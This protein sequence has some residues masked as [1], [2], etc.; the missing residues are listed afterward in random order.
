VKFKK[1]IASLLSILTVVSMIP[2]PANAYAEEKNT[3][4]PKV[5]DTKAAEEDT[6]FIDS[7]IED[8]SSDTVDEMS[9]SEENSSAKKSIMQVS[10]DSNKI[11]VV[12]GKK[13][14]YAV[15]YSS[16]DKFEKENL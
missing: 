13:D 2:V 5:V 3:D 9:E 1:C 10:G 16:G 7:Y 14:T 15:M 8:I 12:D 11:S 6:D 4:V